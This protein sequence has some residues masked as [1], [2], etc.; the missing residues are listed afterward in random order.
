MEK[1][2]TLTANVGA[3]KRCHDIVKKVCGWLAMP[4]EWLRKYYS[5]VLQEEIGRARA[6]AMTNAQ[7]AFFATTL[8]VDYPVIIRI[9]A[10][11]WFVM[12]LRKLRIK[13]N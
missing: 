4:Q 5:L 8:P 11:V 3:A 12:A 6:K 7:L 2:M 13:V 10:C 1:Q 9:A